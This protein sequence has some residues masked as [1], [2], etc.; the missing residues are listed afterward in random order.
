MP[1]EVFSKLTFN[2]VLSRC[3]GKVANTLR[4]RD[5][6]C[7]G[8]AIFS[9][10]AGA[11]WYLATR[12]QNLKIAPFETFT[13][14]DLPSL[15]KFIEHV[16][17]EIKKGHD[18]SVLIK[19]FSAGKTLA[20]ADSLHKV[21]HHGGLIWE[22][23]RDMYLDYVLNNRNRNTH[24]SYKSSLGVCGLADDYSAILGEPL[25]TITSADLIE[26]RDTIVER[27]LSGGGKGA[28]I[29]QANASVAAMKSA[30]KYFLNH[31]KVFR[32]TVNPA[33]DLADTDAR[34][35]YGFKLKGNRPLRQIEI[36]AYIHALDGL[37]NSDVRSALKLQLFT[38][39]RR[40]DPT[41]ATVE[42]FAENDGYGLTWTFEDKKHAWRVLPLTGITEPL[43]REAIK[44]AKAKGSDYLFPKQRVK[45]TGDSM[46]G[47]INERTVSKAVEAMNAEDGVFYGV[48]FAVATH[49]IRRAFISQMRGRMGEFLIGNRQM[50]EDDIEIIT[51]KNE[52]R[53]RC[54]SM[55]YDKTPYLDAK[56][57]ILRAWERYC[58]DGYHMYMS[59]LE[60]E[61]SRQAA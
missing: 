32:L 61:S 59:R 44:I 35:P 31:P 55:R 24:R 21:A 30:F 58:M 8:L 7:P 34:D 20:D 6:D 13:Y 14:E 46:E 25:A 38:G 3:K 41:T 51:H 47:H 1:N 53:D 27:G 52:G 56:L 49:E 40:Y 17:E 33:S 36:G 9:G 11:S 48:E 50:E 18:P 43:V 16:R 42:A 2:K 4:L 22:T 19:A 10:P 39:Q 23:A 57:S 12:D 60:A 45:K 29:A 37:S 28:C 26:V 15:R 54:S 5:S